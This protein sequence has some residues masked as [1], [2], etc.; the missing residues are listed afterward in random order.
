MSV[1]RR[2][3]TILFAD[4]VDFT[5]LSERLDA[6][7]V[8]TI[9]DAYFAVVRETVGRYGGS[10]EKF[11]GDAVM[12]AF[13]LGGT[14]D[15]D[16]AVRAIRAGLAMINGVDSLGAR[17]GLD[18]DALRIRVGVN[19]GEVVVADAVPGE[20]QG[21]QAG[22]VT[23][24]VVNVAARL[25]ASSVPGRVLVGESTAL[26]VAEA[27]EL[28]PPQRVMLKG[29]AEAIRAA[30]VAGVR[31][32]PSRELAMGGMTAP[33]IG[34]GA[35]LDLLRAAA[36]RAAVG[37]VER[38]LIV[39]PPGVGKSRLLREVSTNLAAGPPARPAL[40][41]RTRSRP[42]PGRPFPLVHDLLLEAM[43]GA[44]AGKDLRRGDFEEM[45][46]AAGASSARAAVLA[47]AVWGLIEPSATRDSDGHA[48]VDRDAL[49]ADWSA[50]LRVL[51]E[52]RTVRWWAEDVHWAG[53]DELAFAEALAG[54]PD[55]S[56]LL[57]I[58]SARPSIG[59]GLGA[60]W[61]RLDLAP[62]PPA[63]AGELIE[64]LVGGAIPGDLV[65][66]IAVR[67]DGNP[68]FVEELL[69]TWVSVGILQRDDALDRWRLATSPAA[70]A[71]PASIQAIYA[72]QLDDLPGEA[73]ATARRASVA[74]RRFPVA[75]LARIVSD[76]AA[77]SV[78]ELAR[79]SIVTGPTPDDLLGDM[80]TYRHALVR[81]AGYASLARAERAELHLRL[82]RWLEEAAGSHA[83]S[84]A[85]A[86]GG[87]Y[88][89]AL[90]NASAVAMTV[91]DGLD[92]DALTGLASIWL[93]RAG[94]RALASGALDGA[95]S[96]FR[97]SID[98]SGSADPAT[99]GRRQAR[100]GD[101]L[102]GTG[103]LDE[104]V[105]AYE[106][107]VESFTTALPA[108][109]RGPERVRLLRQLAAAAR[110][111]GRARFE[112]TR[113]G[114]SEAIAARVG[115][116]VGNDDEAAR[117]P[118]ELTSIEARMAL[119]NAP[120][121]L[122]TEAAAVRRRAESIDDPNLLLA[123]I[124]T[125]VTVRTEAGLAGAQDWRELADRFAAVGR[126][127]D[128]ADALINALS[129]TADDDE[130]EL[131]ASQAD[132]VVDAHGLKESQAWLGL[133]HASRFFVRGA[134]DDAIERAVFALDVGERHGYHRAVVRTWFVLSPI[135]AARNEVDLL[136]RASTWFAARELDGTFPDSP[137]G[138]LMHQAV[139]VDLAGAGLHAPGLPEIGWLEPSFGLG[140][141]G[142]DWRAAIERVV[143]AL[144]SADRIED[145]RRAI[146][147]VESV[148]VQADD[149]LGSTSRA[150][151]GAWLAEAEGDPVRSA[152]VARAELA[153]GG[154]GLAPW[155]AWRLL[156]AV[157]RSG[158]ATPREVVRAAEL[159]TSLGLPAARSR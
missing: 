107:A 152:V 14:H 86:I 1:E 120:K 76:G 48:A 55:W 118:L 125:D 40:D 24:D 143:G 34:R 159:A 59:E 65:E 52:G 71:L 74:G 106:G 67:S 13:G 155:W 53:I 105:E 8:A 12:A 140:Y 66:E 130:F 83:D 97:R 148:P 131:L 109:V 117:I 9:Q 129:M 44:R 58:A 33:T 17:L 29:K 4:L 149:P 138:R 99:L 94:D 103:S 82:A 146:S 62:L 7:D 104:A 85:G 121:A 37:G 77:A 154:D 57:V 114:D 113:F 123:A 98:L 38:I 18:I 54:D 90:G 128:A 68:L 156:E 31:S 80:F 111:V 30:L 116:V 101:S 43:D 10:L 56:G 75:A 96:A 132:D 28:D 27:I 2:I 135:A 119:S 139:N 115:A 157:V 122:V 51:A 26:A 16:P 6:E 102:L 93:E 32:S 22:R 124:Q 100:L 87:H 153:N 126:S 46:I 70:I 142:P 89:D 150:L 144:V 50:A 69:R 81:D 108:T 133:V 88:A 19:T 21:T 47:G 95:R 112:Q 15:D 23:G 3:V 39:A 134:W 145:A 45:A 36:D 141:A 35:E 63:A 5:P 25:Q 147:I 158:G 84:V 20:G 79:R 127:A 110:A 64:A 151:L 49:F 136:R 41:W 137:Y 60:D 92:R 91:G 78:D 11:I 42:D 61:R 73:R 72:A